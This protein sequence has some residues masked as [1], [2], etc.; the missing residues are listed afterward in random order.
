MNG[1]NINNI[2]VHMKA[3]IDKSAD[4]SREVAPVYCVR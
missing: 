2:N 3:T 4:D 1:F